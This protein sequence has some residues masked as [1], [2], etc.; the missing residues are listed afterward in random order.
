MIEYAHSVARPI[1]I[2]H[3]AQRSLL[4]IDRRFINSVAVGSGYINSSTP[5]SSSLVFSCVIETLLYARL[6]H[7]KLELVRCEKTSRAGEIAMSEMHVA[8]ISDSILMPV[9]LV[10]MLAHLIVV[11]LFEVLGI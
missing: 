1:A 3:K 9:L 5:K 10:R 8:F 4:I 2:C 7:D 6:R 11:K